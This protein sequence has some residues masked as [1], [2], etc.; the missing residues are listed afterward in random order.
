[1]VEK[2]PVG[3]VEK[4]KAKLSSLIQEDFF[5]VLTSN[6][7]LIQKYHLTLNVV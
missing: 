4:K 2:L 1:M 5:S 7:N 3:L 6:M